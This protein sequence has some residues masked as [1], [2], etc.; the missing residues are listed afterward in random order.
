MGLQMHPNSMSTLIFY[1]DVDQVGFSDT[2][3]ST[4]DYFVFL[5][6]NLLTWSSKRQTTIYRSSVEAEYI[7]VANVVVEI[8]W[9]RNFLLEWG[10]L[11]KPTPLIYCN[12]VS[13]I[14]MQGNP[15]QHQ[16][17][18]PIKIDIHFMREKVQCGHIRVF[19]VPLSFQL[20]NIYTK[21]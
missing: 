12:I 4:S 5:G 10:C 2:R 18:K 8:S 3:S 1:T 9:I 15:I 11:Q 13:A 14:Y 17:T 19:H 20:A 6:D 16:H 21:G 7:I